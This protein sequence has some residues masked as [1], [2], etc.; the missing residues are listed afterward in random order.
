MGSHEVSHGC[1]PVS[2]RGGRVTAAALAQVLLIGTT[3]AVHAQATARLNMA[4]SD[5]LLPATPIGRA[6]VVVGVMREQ[7]AGSGEESLVMEVPPSWTPG[8]PI[9]VRATSADGRYSGEGSAVLP[10]EPAPLLE[11]RLRSGY[12]KEFAEGVRAG[13]FIVRTD[14]ATCAEASAGRSR[15]AYSE[16]EDH[17][18][19]AVAQWLGSP[20][21]TALLVYVDSGAAKRVTARLE[22]ADRRLTEVIDCAAEDSGQ[23]YDHTCRIAL[24]GVPPEEATLVIERIRNG[25]RDDPA[26]LSLDLRR[27]Q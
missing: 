14:R 16:D 13:R 22:G 21:G 15:A 18:A 9:C 3:G 8:A 27:R 6:E 24:D 4:Y 11:L 2:R 19:V 12:P 7:V 25:G 26:K 1:R 20:E 5:E 10:A 23:S 17:P